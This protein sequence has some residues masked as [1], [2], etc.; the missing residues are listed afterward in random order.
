[1]WPVPVPADCTDAIPAAHWRRPNAYLDGA[2]RAAAS[3]LA[4]L[5]RVVL[6]PALRRLDDDLTSGRWHERHRGLLERESLDV[7]YR[8]VVRNRV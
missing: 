1:V 6:D 5:P 2:V 7:G 3:G 4:T 8:L